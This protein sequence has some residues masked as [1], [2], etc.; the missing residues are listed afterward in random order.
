ML[1]QSVV[2]QALVPFLIF[3]LTHLSRV[4]VLSVTPECVHTSRKNTH[5]HTHTDLYIYTHTHV[6]IHIYV[7]TY[8]FVYIYIYIYIFM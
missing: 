3:L 2:T 6:Y 5:T 1:L 8:I 7:C 4:V